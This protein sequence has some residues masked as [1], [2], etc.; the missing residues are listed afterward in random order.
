MR[1]YRAGLL[2]LW[3]ML[4]TA[5]NAGAADDL[6]ALYQQVGLMPW[7]FR[8]PKAFALRDIDGKTHTPQDYR[9]KVVILYMF[10]EG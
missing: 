3:V 1:P 5:S 8:Q 2:A 4:L 6:K 9:G 10:S 7:T